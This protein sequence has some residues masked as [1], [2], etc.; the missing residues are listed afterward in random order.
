MTR[1]D[2]HTRL[3]VDCRAGRRHGRHA[4]VILFMVIVCSVVA[5]G[6]RKLAEDDSQWRQETVQRAFNEVSVGMRSSW[7]EKYL[8][9][10]GDSAAPEIMNLLASKGLT[11]KNAETAL[12]LVK[13]SFADPRLIRRSPNRDPVNTLALL[14]YLDQHTTDAD[15]KS[16]INSMREQL[17]AQST[18]KEL[19]K[20]N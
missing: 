6:E 15:T 3:P 16:T 18:G 20:S 8:A 19:K 1:C 5:I 13:M 12:T 2:L 9:R 7:S 14:G 4:L 17:Q 11:K 10:L